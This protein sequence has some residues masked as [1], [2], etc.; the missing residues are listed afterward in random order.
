MAAIAN[1]AGITKGTLYHYFSGKAEIL[2]A[3]LDNT[4]LSSNIVR[5]RMKDVA[6]PIEERLF[7]LAS[8]F[9]KMMQVRPYWSL[10]MIRE[11]LGAPRDDTQEAVKDQFQGLLQS[12]IDALGDHLTEEFHEIPER[13]VRLLAGAFFHTLNGYWILSAHIK[14]EELEPQDCEDHARTAARQLA[15]MLAQRNE[16]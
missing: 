13:E 5:E 15:C 4:S 8:G 7:E 12:R 9:L 11:S 14:S 3:V 6:R 16:Q 10:A 2:E 1:A